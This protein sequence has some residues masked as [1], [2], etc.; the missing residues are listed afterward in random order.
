VTRWLASRPDNP[1]LPS[2]CHADGQRRRVLRYLAPLKQ[3]FG[4]KQAYNTEVLDLVSLGP[5]LAVLGTRCDT[6]GVRAAAGAGG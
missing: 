4:P 1:T 2:F 6:R 5:R 3:A